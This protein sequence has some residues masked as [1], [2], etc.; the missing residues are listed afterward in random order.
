MLQTKLHVFVAHFNVPLM[1]EAG[2]H[3]QAEPKLTLVTP[4]SCHH[5]LDFSTFSRL[6]HEI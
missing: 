6:D 2:Y 1:P 3:L 5:D 4:R